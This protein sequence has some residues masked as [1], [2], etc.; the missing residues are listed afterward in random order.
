VSNVRL[1]TL[2][3]DAPSGKVL[4]VWDV[5]RGLDAPPGAVVTPLTP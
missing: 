5:D 4:W 2:E 1:S 3:E